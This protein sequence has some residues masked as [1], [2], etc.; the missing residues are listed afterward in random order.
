MDLSHTDHL[1]ADTLGGGG[2]VFNKPK[3]TSTDEWIEVAW[4][5]RSTRPPAF[6]P[7]M[8][9]NL[10]ELVDLTLRVSWFAASAMR[11][12]ASVRHEGKAGADCHRGTTA[13]IF[14]PASEDS[15]PS[16]YAMTRNSA[17]VDTSANKRN[18]EKT[19]HTN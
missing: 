18:P 12:D 19:K 10:P 3:V 15:T 8:I 11:L 14:S 13:P 16:F 6:Y 5:S 4:Q 17:A 2:V 7:R 1:H 9:P